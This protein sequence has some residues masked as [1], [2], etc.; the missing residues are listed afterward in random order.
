M[1]GFADLSW[2]AVE[3]PPQPPH[4]SLDPMITGYRK[5]PVAQIGADLFCDT[6]TIAAE[7]ARLSGRP[8]LAASGR[9]GADI[10]YLDHIEGR[11][12]AACLGS[13]PKSRMLWALA[14]NLGFGLPRFVKDRAGISS[15]NALPWATRGSDNLHTVY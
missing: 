6:R 7:V 12:F 11:I 2:Q 8:E 1:L 14:T 10:Q 5:S 4:P 13:I 9:S 15:L 3:V